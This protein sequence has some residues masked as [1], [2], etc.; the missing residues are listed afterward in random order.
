MNETGIRKSIKNIKIGKIIN[1]TNTEKSKINSLE[2]NDSFEI[3]KNNINA[4]PLHL[5]T[6][7]N[8]T[9]I[10]NDFN[11]KVNTK[12]IFNN[13]INDNNISNNYYKIREKENTKSFSE[14]KIAQSDINIDSKNINK[15]TRK[16]Y[17]NIKLYINTK[18]SKPKIIF[19]KK[20]IDFNSNS[21]S[22]D[23]KMK[24]IKNL[25]FIKSQNQSINENNYNS[26]NTL[27]IKHH[28]T[29]E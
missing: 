26:I 1:L 16:K 14:N 20:D 4:F 6:N 8:I 29:N 10:S 5:K 13:Y 21:K 15:E 17:K 18:N 12:Y 22:N 25:Y 23:K 19:N 3:E 28:I 11:K 2:Y 9:D 27:S 24:L 7:P